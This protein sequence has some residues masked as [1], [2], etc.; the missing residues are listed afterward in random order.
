MERHL[1]ERGAEMYTRVS[2]RIGRTMGNRC[3]GMTARLNSLKDSVHKEMWHAY[4]T[5]IVAKEDGT[6]AVREG[7]RKRLVE[8]DGLFKLSS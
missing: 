1:R 5:T 6:L 4:T 2:S 8:A 3:N 7:V